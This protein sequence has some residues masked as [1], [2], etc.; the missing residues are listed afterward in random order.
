MPITKHDAEW[1][2]RV[3]TVHK[4]EVN[5]AVVDEQV[6]DDNSI[7]ESETDDEG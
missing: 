2:M 7:S 5:T 4:S 3:R 6:T 1:A